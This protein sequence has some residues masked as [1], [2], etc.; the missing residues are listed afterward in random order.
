M[1]WGIFWDFDTNGDQWLDDFVYDDNLQFKKISTHNAEA[2]WHL[3]SSGR[4]LPKRWLHTGVGQINNAEIDGVVTLFPP[5]AVITGMNNRLRRNGMMHVA[6]AFNLGHHPH[7]WKRLASAFAL[8]KIDR[9]I[10][11]SAGEVK[12]IRELFELS[13]KQVEFVHL[14]C[15]DLPV[16]FEENRTDPFVVAI[17][18]ANRD[19]VTLIEALRITGL[20][21]K[22]VTAPRLASGLVAPPNVEILAGLSWHECQRLT[23]QARICIIPLADPMIAT[24]QA[25]LVGALTMGR[26]VIATRSIGTVDYIEDGRTGA[27]V[28]PGDVNGLATSIQWLWDD[29]STRCL[30]ADAAKA[31]AKS[32]LSDAVIAA[33][34]REVL[35]DVERSR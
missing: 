4:S 1:R 11:H 9:L 19:L 22:I 27:L 3:R 31:F 18:S 12:I 5:L 26:P 15:P 34:F 33:R 24:G 23:Q 7:G 10:V 8:A 20:P 6:W 28:A 16:T 13:E 29:D 32:T 25:T 35:E 14:Q 30:M 21:A 17:G 2:N